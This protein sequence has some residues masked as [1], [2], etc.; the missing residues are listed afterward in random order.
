MTELRRSRLIEWENP[1]A[2]H[3]LAGSMTGLE[4]LKAIGRQ[5]LPKPPM[6][7]TLGIEALAAEEG[8]VTLAVEPQEYH[9]NPLGVAHGGLAATLADT[10][11]GCAVHSM[12]KAGVGYTTIELKMNFVRPLKS[13]MGRVTCEGI[14]LHLGSR[15]AT[16]E[17]RVVD[18]RG[19]LH[20]HGTSTC[21]LIGAGEASPKGSR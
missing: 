12:L 20:A 4:F 1:A 21:L 15:I 19:R 2:F 16:A 17:A 14:L 9:Y 11:M 18:D 13:G 8:R 10:A 7:S 5:E 3:E 6:M